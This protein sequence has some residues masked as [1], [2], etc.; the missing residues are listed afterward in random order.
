MFELYKAIAGSPITYLAADI[1]ANQTTISIADDSALPDAPNICTIGYGE[2][3][4][5]IKYGTKSN[6]VLQNVTRGIEGT[7]RAWPAGTEVARFFTAYDHNAII[8]T[9]VAHQT[10]LN[11]IENGIYDISDCSYHK[12]S[13]GGSPKLLIK[14]THIEID[15]DLISSGSLTAGSKLYSD[16]STTRRATLITLTP[17]YH[18]GPW[19]VDIFDQ[20]ELST[21]AFKFGTSN[22]VF[23]ITHTG[24]AYVLGN[25]MVNGYTLTDRRRGKTSANQFYIGDGNCRIDTSSGSLRLYTSAFG[26]ND[27][28]LLVGADGSL[29]IKSANV[30]KHTFFANGSKNGG[31]I[32][33]EGT[34]Y[35]MSPIDSPQVLIED[36]LFDVK[37]NGR[38]KIQLDNIFAKSISQYAVFSSCG[39]VEIV[40][41]G[42]DYFI[43]D[44]YTGVA[45]FRIV[46]KRVDEEHR[47]FEIMGGFA[48][49]V[50]E[51]VNI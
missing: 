1:S 46:G 22:D 47:Y 33:I 21:L 19:R 7:P 49:G 6:G 32:E 39:Q 36:V 43:V 13:I 14:D 18:A 48:H 51:E 45:D 24:H 28:G 44:G 29:Q 8:N 35:G 17:P 20:T 25:I 15:G 40:E 50:E 16:A 11:N 38:T 4:E 12:F 2:N 10:D 23:T 34:T 30:V 3:L 41:K 42:E 9:L 26:S 27:N 31:S 5:T 37:V